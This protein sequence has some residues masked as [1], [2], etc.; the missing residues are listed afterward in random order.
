MPKFKNNI[1]NSSKI[2]HI[3][4]AILEYLLDDGRMSFSQLAKKV[5]ISRVMVAK[6]VENLQKQGVIEKFTV[7]VSRAYSRK[8]LPVFFDVIVN[9]EQID[10]AAK[11]ISRHDDIFVVY[12]MSGRSSLHVHGY[13]EDIEEVYKF[14]HNQMNKLPGIQNVSTEFLLK[15]FKVDFI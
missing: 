4:R 14:I 12:Q 6:R 3:D 9:P 15:K 13:F 8:P 10:N 5:G 1:H 11:K 2:D 7:L